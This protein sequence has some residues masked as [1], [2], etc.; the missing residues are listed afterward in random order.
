MT[1]I[2]PQ[3]K[4]TQGQSNSI[5]LCQGTSLE[6]FDLQTKFTSFSPVD[7]S[8]LIQIDSAYYYAFMFFSI[9]IHTPLGHHP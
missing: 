2:A 5:M 6:S 8:C 3:T 1:K 7:M 4:E 9:N